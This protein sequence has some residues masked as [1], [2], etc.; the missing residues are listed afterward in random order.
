MLLAKDAIR[1]AVECGDIEIRP[2]NAEQLNPN[3]YDLRLSQHLATYRQDQVL[4]AKNAPAIERFSIPKSGILLRP[5]KLYL[6]STE[7][8][9]YTRKYV[10]GIEGR[11]SVGR[12]G[13]N[14]HATAGF[15]D[16]GFCGAWTLEIS[17][18]EPVRIYAGMRLCQIYWTTCTDIDFDDMYRGKYRDQVMPQPSSI[19]R[20]R[21]EWHV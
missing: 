12:L 4:D 13:I 15:G 9:T 8:V 17:V 20:E 14:I 18:V 16:I 19:F 3:S 7:E 11:S 6:G 1:Q 21:N 10:P 2:F 5:G